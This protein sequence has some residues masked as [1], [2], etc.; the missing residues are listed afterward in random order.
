LIKRRLDEKSISYAYFRDKESMA[1]DRKI[2]SIP[3][4][5]ADGR[6]MNFG[7]AVKWISALGGEDDVEN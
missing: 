5:D 4:L 6:R 3:V 7:E 2:T 1:R